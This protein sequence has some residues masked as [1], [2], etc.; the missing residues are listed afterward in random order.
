MPA[1]IAVDTPDYQRGIVNAQ[2]LLATGEG[3]GGPVTVTLPPNCETLIVIITALGGRPV[4]K[5][6]GVS[7]G[8]VYPGV[9]FPSQFG[10]AQ[11]YCWMFDVTSSLDAQV[12]VSGVG[13]ALTPYAIY[14]D[15]GVHITADMSKLS[16]SIGQQYI[17]P[18]VPSTL[19]GDHPPN[20]LKYVSV[21]DLATPATILPALGVGNRYRIFY[22]TMNMAD[23]NVLSDLRD[24]TPA[25]PFL[26]GATGAA[27]TP[28]AASYLPSGIPL[29]ANSAITGT[30]SVASHV[31]ATI[32]YTTEAV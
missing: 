25:T 3:G 30:C 19:A 18:S 13:A 22:A 6:S 31:T 28:T 14:A 15:S 17:I 16:N 32:A 2:K 24:A 8:H 4:V 23:A 11:D 27:G 10:Q 26:H 29:T 21:T 12:S 1:P 20:E 9:P 5:V 7:T